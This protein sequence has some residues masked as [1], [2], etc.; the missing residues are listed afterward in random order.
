[1]ISNKYIQKRPGQSED[2]TLSRLQDLARSWGGELVETSSEKLKSLGLDSM[3]K[4]KELR[5]YYE[6]PF[7]DSYS[8]GILLEEFKVLYVPGRVH[9]SDI[10]HEM[11]HIFAT[12]MPPYR[13]DEWGFF[14]WEYA[15][16]IHVGG[17]LSEWLRNNGDYAVGVVGG[18][19]L[20][21]GGLT[22]DQRDAMLIERWDFAVQEGLI[23]SQGRP[24]AVRSACDAP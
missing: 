12:K 18:G 16:A 10:I 11:G 4:S 21:L 1:M 3:K 7:S 2:V 19:Y 9:W 6:S 13:V 20:E 8:L 14:G 23:D 15:V 22:S 17:E 5:E 24:L